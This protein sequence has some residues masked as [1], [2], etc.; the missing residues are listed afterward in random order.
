[1]SFYIHR[2]YLQEHTDRLDRQISELQSLENQVRQL[3]HTGD[4]TDAFALQKCLRRLEQVRHSLT[5]VRRVL[6]EHHT[7]VTEYGPERI[8]V[9]AHKGQITVLGQGMKLCRMSDRQLIISGRIQGVAL[10]RG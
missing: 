1:M 5:D 6:I 4:G 2:G 9:Q 10:S 3:L 8:C 7:G